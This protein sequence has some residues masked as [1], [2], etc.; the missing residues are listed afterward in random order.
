MR[1]TI[2]FTRPY[3]DQATQYLHFISGKLVAELKYVNEHTVINLDAKTI[4][5]DY[6]ESAVKSRNP[7]LVVLNGHG[8]KDAI[9]GDDRE[10]ILDVNNVHVL[11]S[12]IV[13]AVA[14]D[15]LEG[16]GELA[17]NKGK[18]TSYIGYGANFMIIIDP[19]R[20]AV[21]TKDKNVQPFI[22][23]YA[24]TILS[25]ISGLT[26]AKSIENTKAKIKSLIREYG[27]SG[28]MDRCGDAP[29]IRWALHWDLFFLD[30]QGDAEACF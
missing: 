3:Y 6:F 18:A 30:M 9:Y 11:N 29:L 8:S 25:I 28:I 4:S 15:S 19:S 10:K 20:T 16:L 21:P 13:Y 17:I 14:C 23:V 24:M 5:R 2:L 7:R 27:V 12:K 22:Q 26:I 1:K